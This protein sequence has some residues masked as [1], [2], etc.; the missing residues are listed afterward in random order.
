MFIYKY[1][2]AGNRTR[3]HCDQWVWFFKPRLL[4]HWRSE[5]W[6]GCKLLFIISE[7]LKPYR[8][9]DVFQVR[10]ADRLPA[11]LFGVSPGD[12]QEGHVLAGVV[13]LPAGNTHQRGSERDYTTLLLWTGPQVSKVYFLTMDVRLQ[14]FICFQRRIHIWYTEQGKT[15]QNQ[16]SLN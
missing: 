6:K 8:S 7:N 5:G 11:V 12:V 10:N 1:Y 3:N 14:I 13:D 9:N 4:H 2:H 15:K 16:F